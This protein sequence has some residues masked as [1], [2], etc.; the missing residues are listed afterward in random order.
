[1]YMSKFENN[2]LP[3]D[4]FLPTEQINTC[5]W[6]DLS[7]NIDLQVLTAGADEPDLA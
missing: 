4:A 1:M 6:L 7:L 2:D 5:K 3:Q